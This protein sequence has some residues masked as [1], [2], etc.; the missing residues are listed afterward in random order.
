MVGQGTNH[1]QTANMAAPVVGA[2][3]LPN[4]PAL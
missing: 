1:C 2:E 3:E 4:L